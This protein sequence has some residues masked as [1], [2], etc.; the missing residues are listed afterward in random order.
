IMESAQLDSFNV[1]LTINGLSLYS[2]TDF[3]DQCMEWKKKYGAN[4]PALSINLLRFPSFMSGLALPLDLRKKRKAEIERWYQ[5]H[6]D[7]PLFQIHERESLIR[8]MD[9]LDTVQQPHSNSSDSTTAAL[10]FKTFYQQY[11]QRRGKSFEKTFPKELTD[12]YK[13]IPAKS[14]SSFLK[15]KYYTLRSMA[16]EKLNRL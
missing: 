1:M 4:K 13:S 3:L 6:I 9:Y 15:Q 11:D 2:L 14:K 8:L 5:A 16:R 12:W 7:N 10:D